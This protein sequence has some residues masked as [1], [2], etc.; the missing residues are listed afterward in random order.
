MHVPYISQWD[1]TAK[2]SRGDCGIVSACMIAQWAGIDTTPDAMLL[3]SK[4]PIGRK[5]YDFNEIIR[6]GQAVGLELYHRS[7]ATWDV[8]RNELILGNPVISLLRYGKISGNLDDFDGPH[9]W[10]L[11]GFT[12]DSVIVHDPNWWEPHRAKG[13]YRQVPLGEFKNA[14]SVDALKPTGNNGYQSLFVK[15]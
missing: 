13:M 1:T 15:A 3:K 5:T 4:L 7:G 6:A 8:L 2:L 10:L 14:I 12:P 9:F 11:V